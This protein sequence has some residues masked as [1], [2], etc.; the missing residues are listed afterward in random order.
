[1]EFIPP[2]ER[3]SQHEK[4]ASTPPATLKAAVAAFGMD[5]A[6]TEVRRLSGGF[7]NA[8]FLATD[9]QQQ[10]V[11]RVYSTDRNTAARE[12]DLLR[13]L[14]ARPITAPRALA[15]IDVGTTPVVALEYIDGETLEDRL[16]SGVAVPLKIFEK[17]GRELGAVHNVQFEDAGFIGPKVEVGRQFDNFSVFLRSFIERTLKDLVNRPDKLDLQTNERCRQLV[18]EKWDAVLASEPRRQLVHCDFNPK[19]IMVT[20]A[21]DPDVAGVIDWEFCMAGNGLIDAGNFFRFEYD[22]PAGAKAAFAA[23]YRAVNASLP[24]DWDD[25]ARLLDLGNMCSFLE[26]REDYQ[27][28]FRTARVVIEATL[29]HF[30]Y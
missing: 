15:V 23:G 17:I 18:L 30:G 3:F 20:K 29:R 1:M 6:A 13:F 22:Y 10:I 5:P 8:N 14:E 2:K 7:M 4:S 28:S 27:K 16:L 19:N 24:A 12:F 9:R 11:I 21:T 26:R 25:I